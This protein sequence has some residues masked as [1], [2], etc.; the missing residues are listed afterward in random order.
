MIWCGRALFLI[1]IPQMCST[2]RNRNRLVS[3]KWSWTRNRCQGSANSRGNRFHP[4]TKVTVITTWTRP[5]M[6]AKKSTG[7][8]WVIVEVVGLESV[9]SWMSRSRTQRTRCI[10]LQPAG[11]D[12]MNNTD[13]DPLIELLKRIY[14]L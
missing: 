14:T 5:S 12:R 6:H 7:L 4:I 13:R 2:V 8:W 3:K 1:K 9:R 11:T 10:R